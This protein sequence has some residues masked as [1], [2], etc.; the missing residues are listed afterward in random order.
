VI[1]HKITQISTNLFYQTLRKFDQQTFR[2]SLTKNAAQA[3]R[4]EKLYQKNLFFILTQVSVF[5]KKI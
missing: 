4:K 2:K 1:N 3:A 5:L